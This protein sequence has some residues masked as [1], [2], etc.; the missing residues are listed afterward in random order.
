MSA[1]LALPLCLLPLGALVPGR[2]DGAPSASGR[3]IVAVRA[4]TIHLVEDGRVLRDGVLLI[5]DGKIQ[6]VGEGLELPLDTT[7]IDYGKDAV[8][9]PGLVAAMSP[10]ALG[11]SSKRT[12]DPTVR[13]LDGFDSYRSYVDGL[14]GG[15]TSAYLTPADNRLIAGVG[16]VVKLGGEREAGRVLSGEAA[17]HGAIDAAARGVA[18]YWEP[19]IPAA[20][21]QDLG[22]A[23][24][25]LPRTTSGA[26]V[27]LEELLDGSGRAEDPALAREYGR[28]TASALGALL[29]ERVP[30]RLA[31]SEASEIR[32]LLA[33]AARRHVPVV[34]DRAEG[35]REVADE[36]AAAGLSVVYRVPYFPNSGASDRG[37]A[38]DARWLELDAP[39]ALV[40]AGAR[41]AITGWSTRDLLFAARIASRGGLESAA[42]LRAIT[43][44]PAEILGV[45]GRVGSLREGK[46]ADLCVLNGD[47]L[48]PGSSVL[49]TWIDGQVV[50]TP[51]AETRATVLEVDELHVGDGRILRP[52]Q[53]LLAGG[54]I[55][56]VG[57]RVAHPV[58][59]TVVRGWAAMPGMIDAFGHLGLEGSR[60]MVGADFELATI[61]EPGDEVDRKV[62]L[63]G[64]TT[65]ALSPRGTND[66]GA[67]MM[68]YK[69]AASSLDDQVVG[70]P[71]AVRLR[72]EDQSRPRNGQNVRALLERAAEYRGKW[73]EYEEA[74]AN[75]TPPPAGAPAEAKS[76][77]KADEKK[78]G[79]SAEKKEEEKPAEEKK[80]EGAAEK[81]DDSKS[82]K[83][84]K[85]EP[86][87]L[88]PD[89]VT[90]QWQGEIAIGEAKHVL[91]L[92]TKL[93]KAGA[94]G[95]IEGNLRCEVASSAL[96]TI[97]GWLDREKRSVGL[98]GIGT[99]GRVE[100]AGEL[101]EG[102]LVAKLTV[103]GKAHEVTLE[104]KSKEYVVARRSEP[105]E[106]KPSEAAPEPKGKPKEPRRD[107]KLEPLRRAMD[108]EAA[109]VI[110]V[111]RAG[112]ILAC[113]ETFERFGIRPILYGA[114]EAHLVADELVG[115]VG[116][117]FLTPTVVGFDAKRG[118]DY[119]TPYAD[120]QNAGLR[121]AFLSEAEEGAI[122]LPLRAAYA[123]ANGMSP[124]GAL[125]ALTADAADMLAISWRVGRL[126]TGLD[127]DVLLLDGPPLEPE[128]SV[129]RAWVNG[130]EVEAP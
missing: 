106:E 28:R 74:M 88:E 27:A 18:G 105:G 86:E 20:P 57:E 100:L 107:A 83:K 10:Y 21:D 87:E 2:G 120:L 47:P 78:N 79:E 89:P 94:S 96:V 84:K 97:E 31:A 39:A 114:R 65:V 48:A 19:P 1:K 46:D 63:H 126:A 119:P 67:P 7:V 35:A 91:K 22:Y 41:V 9:V 38:D 129:M 98:K 99:N 112:D 61:V 72:W 95:A 15:V 8:V 24:P 71:I 124:D 118:T 109:I 77:E 51:K 37:K 113:V 64:I 45:A 68:A 33:F 40:R 53:L 101:K 110:D 90:G 17:I 3:G 82:K 130:E 70:D 92:R 56:E 60:R 115:R 116:G 108:G 104:R 4:G 85:G 125:R 52:G 102:K 13:A 59:A 58:G 111:D 66:A 11:S 80:D 123:V 12:A 117:L 75:W 42:A 50:W 26:I 6:A 76:E 73:R 23:R 29:A 43:L 122:D 121:V 14:S 16:A 30:L 55:R 25:Q 32:A 49:A 44:A 81:K 128:T 54:K 62:A 5:K 93:A 69:P 34:I 127:G 103:G 36:I